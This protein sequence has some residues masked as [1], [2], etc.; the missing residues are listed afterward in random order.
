MISDPDDAPGSSYECEEA[1]LQLR[2]VRPPEDL[3][4]ARAERTSRSRADLPKSIF[5][6][7]AD[8]I[9]L[10]CVTR[11]ELRIAT[12][13]EVFRLTRGKL[14]VIER[15]VYHAE[16]VAPSGP[17][18][19]VTWLHLRKTQAHAARASRRSRR[20]GAEIAGWLLPGSSNVEEL[21]GGIVDELSLRAWDHPTAVAGILDYLTCI[22]I[23]RARRGA[24][25]FR[26]IEQRP[27]ILLD[28]RE[29]ALVQGALDFCDAHFREGVNQTDV[30]RAL[31][32]NSRYLGRVVSRHLGYS[33]ARHLRNLR[34]AEAKYLLERTNLPVHAVAAG[35][36]YA[37]PEHF[38]RAFARDTGISPAGFRQRLDSR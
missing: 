31:G 14:L 6:H 34:L 5:E 2:G 1:L 4:L 19:E 24:A 7:T 15:G 13:A 26:P 35:V 11:G 12:P 17:A 25:V 38:I 29:S 33:I 9:E 8:T 28:P 20:G 30:A 21:A 36:G 10:A 18:C 3:L 23:R 32:Y 27:A 37:Y 22:L 16:L